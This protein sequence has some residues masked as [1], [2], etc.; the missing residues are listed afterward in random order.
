MPQLQT[1]FD[2]N[3]KLEHHNMRA[4][5]ARKSAKFQRARAEELVLLV[6]F[7]RAGGQA[8]QLWEAWPGARARARALSRNQNFKITTFLLVNF[9]NDHGKSC[10]VSRD[11][12][13]PK[14]SAQSVPISKSYDQKPDFQIVRSAS[15]FKQ[16][17][18]IIQK[19]QFYYPESRVS[20]TKCHVR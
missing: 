20:N 5:R 2:E 1:K 17:M 12:Q 3:Q 15:L 9:K 13:P 11:W 8:P 14:I 16:G 6:F 4:P 18:P 10:S 19:S 7:E